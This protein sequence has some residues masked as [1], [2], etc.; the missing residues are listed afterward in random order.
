MKHAKLTILLGILMSIPVVG[1]LFAASQEQW[2][3]IIPKS[4]EGV[5]VR[6]AA[7]HNENFGVW[8]GAGEE[9]AQH[10]TLDGG[11]TWTKASTNG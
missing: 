1:F 3:I 11:K 10:Y 9:G 4:A 8:G 6:M 2:E 7:F 5:K